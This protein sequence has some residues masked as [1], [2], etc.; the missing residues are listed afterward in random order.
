MY[1]RTLEEEKD[2]RSER[3]VHDAS[4]YALQTETRAARTLK[5]PE[6]LGGLV[7][8]RKVVKGL[9]MAQVAPGMGEAGVYGEGFRSGEGDALLGHPR[10][11][12]PAASASA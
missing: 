9:G 6:R 8:P 7:R 10:S 3:R 12:T 5:G 1:D 11:N 4:S 2:E